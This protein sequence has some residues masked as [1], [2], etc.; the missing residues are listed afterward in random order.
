MLFTCCGKQDQNSFVFRRDVVIHGSAL[1]RT[2]EGEEFYE[3]C[4]P[5][6]CLNSLHLWKT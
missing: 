5:L 2:R 4:A 1:H 6:D 3:E